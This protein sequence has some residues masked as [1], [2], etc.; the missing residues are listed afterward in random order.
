[1]IRGE[2]VYSETSRCRV[3]VSLLL[4]SAAA[5]GLIA[6]SAA[7]AQESAA[8]QTYDV[9]AQPLN[10]ALAT[11]G[12]QSGLQ[13][14]VD[15]AELRG[16]ESPG[17]TGTLTARA[18]L[19]RLLVGSAWQAR[20]VDRVVTLERAPQ[21]AAGTIITGPLRV[22]AAQGSAKTAGEDRDARG[23]DD[24]YDKDTTTTYM[25][26]DEVERYKGVT[27][28]DV[29]K[30]ML[31]VY[32]GDPRN[33]GAIDPS[34]R[35]ISGPGRVPVIVDGTEQALTVW[36][37][38]NGVSNRSY[39]DPNLISGIQIQ[40]GP[41]SERGI[42]G[43]IG[44]AVVI[45]TL[46]AD[47]IL[48]KGQTF[49]IEA[50]IEGGNNSTSPRW[51]TLLTGRD[52]R[53]VPNFLEPPGLQT[54]PSFP[55]FDPS[56][57]IT[58]RTGADNDFVSFGNK[59][60]RVAVAGRLG[61][62]DL[63]GAYAYRT[64]GNYFSG[65]NNAGYYLQSDLEQTPGNFVQRMGLS[66][67]P[68]IEVANT[69]SNTSS[70]L[71]KVV[72]HIDDASYL[73]AG[74]RDTLAHYGDILPSRI[75]VDRG[76]LGA[77]Q[78][79][80]ARVRTQAYDA[81]YRLRPD[82]WWLDLKANFWATHTISATN[83]LGGFPN[84]ASVADPILVN[85][86]IAHYRNDRM[87]VI[88]SNQ[89]KLGS[90]LD[91]LVQGNWQREVLRS[92]DTLDRSVA[93]NFCQYPRSGRREE[94]RFDAK[95]EWRPVSFLKFNAG[96][97]YAGF[98]ATDD[99]LRRLVASGSAPQTFAISR[100]TTAIN[101]AVT[102][103]SS[104]RYVQYQSWMKF[105]S[106]PDLAN[107]FADIDVEN[108]TPALNADYKL[109]DDQE[110]S[111]GPDGRFRRSD[112]P[113]QNGFYANKPG[114]DPQSC[115]IHGITDGYTASDANAHNARDA[116]APMASATAYLSSTSRVYVR[117][118][119]AYRFPSVF[120]STLGFS[121]SFNPLAKLK[122]EHLHSTEAAFIQD[123]RPV[124]GLAGS[125][126]KADLKLTWYRN[127]TTDVIERSTTL[128]FSN[129]DKQVI[130]GI[131]AQARFDNGHVFGDLGY[132]HVFTNQACDESRAMQTD[133]SHSALQR[134]PNCVKYGFYGGYLLTQAA[135]DDSLNA[136]I[137]ARFLDRRLEVGQRYTWYSEYDN[138]QLR[139]LLNGT[140]PIDGVSLNVPY[141]WGAS[142]T[143]DAYVR[144]RINPRF[145]A[146][147]DGTN[148][149][150]RYYG[151]PLTRSL[152]PAPGRTVRIG[153]T[154]RL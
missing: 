25:G 49:G 60:A 137:G 132:A 99:L 133:A 47:D 55:Y 64:Q 127:V 97:T 51:P 34:I 111:A 78:W 106:D 95:A 151:D 39:I 126:Q 148:L 93:C 88:A 18:A 92:Q 14:S 144:F 108:Y 65:K 9:A 17:V 110:F 42:D 22:E 120:E 2:R 57:R 154:A 16:I 98:A 134:I 85:T 116:W 30:G 107:M 87:G 76:G 28:S 13:V 29:L 71:A 130:S 153:L 104:Y 145:T 48:R 43:A 74:F 36:R 8:R 100:Y 33:G 58:P 138:R 31:G 61:S 53:D 75:I 129:I 35:G 91:L 32:S 143:V 102:D 141:A 149:T 66:Y 56:L 19:D 121:G 23:A 128:L 125:D 84:S 122:P 109:Q 112:N 123:L 38:Y 1:M 131:E 82:T 68:G 37:G 80:E 52:H 46:D 115:S 45:H 86:A 3:A 26:K 96:I 136:T 24:I 21:S 83:N 135:P 70:W 54:Q 72:W 50:R 69:S 114:Y 94:Y 11:F 139:G 73:K 101:Y 12:M 117:Y 15:A 6:P 147:I 79:P 40:K 67:L 152:N 10:S 105:F 90:R 62:I 59:A 124:L 140:P 27:S 119:E 150:D 77:V 4:A 81:E 41:V 44:G 63:F 89:F 146:E 20:I 7:S 103:K 113:C 118:A 5:G 142:L